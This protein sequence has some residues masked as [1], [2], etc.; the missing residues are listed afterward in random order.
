MTTLR[1]STTWSPREAAEGRLDHACLGV[2]PRTLSVV[3]SCSGD[4]AGRHAGG[5]A[6]MCFRCVLMF[7][8]QVV[9]SISKGFTAMVLRLWVSVSARPRRHGDHG[10]KSRARDTTPV[11][12]GW[13]AVRHAPHGVLLGVAT[14][15]FPGR[16]RSRESFTQDPRSA[17]KPLGLIRLTNHSARGVAPLQR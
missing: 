5:R 13:F 4:V 16:A 17:V 15:A 10:G 11:V 9:S 6:A 3:P 8:R 7:V 12:G 1:L 14:S 2:P